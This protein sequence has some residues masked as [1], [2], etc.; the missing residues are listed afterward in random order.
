MAPECSGGGPLPVARRLAFRAN[1]AE[2]EAIVC[3]SSRYLMS[4]VPMTQ[5]LS[6]ALWGGYAVYDC[7]S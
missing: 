5:L 2:G 7:E 4:L 3:S 6:D 1:C